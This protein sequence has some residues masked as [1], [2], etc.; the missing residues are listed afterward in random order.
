M[1][2]VRKSKDNNQKKQKRRLLDIFLTREEPDENYLPELKSQWNAMDN[3]ERVRF[4][5]GALVGLIIILGGMFLI[6]YLISAMQ[7]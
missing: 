5:L 2:E 7:S 6:Y 4:I 1:P 3:R